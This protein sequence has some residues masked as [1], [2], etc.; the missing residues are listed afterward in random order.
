MAVR[1]SLYNNANAATKQ[2]DVDFVHNVL[3]SEY[4]ANVSSNSAEYY[5]KL[6]PI[7]SAV[8]DTD[9]V[10]VKTEVNL[11]LSDLALNSVKQSA[12]PD[13]LV[14]GDANAY[15]DITSMVAD[16]IYDMAKGHTANQFSSGCAVKAAM[17][18]SS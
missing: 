17:S 2:V 6:S 5:F 16:Y 13:S 10:V 8:V 11:S 1:V 7:N 18:F 3:A 14:S 12:N 15:S 4:K 9:G